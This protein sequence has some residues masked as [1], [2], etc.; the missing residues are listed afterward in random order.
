MVRKGEKQ[1]KGF[2]LLDMEM[3]PNAGRTSS[4]SHGTATPVL[5]R[6]LSLNS[7]VSQQHKVRSQVLFYVVMV[8]LL[9]LLCSCHGRTLCWR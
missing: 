7:F 2:S 1:L 3:I 9:V 6:H 8:N 5:L 4:Q